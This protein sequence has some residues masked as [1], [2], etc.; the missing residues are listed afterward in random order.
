MGIYDRIVRRLATISK[1]SD[2]RCQHACAMVNYRSGE[3]VAEGVNYH[4]HK[5]QTKPWIRTKRKAT[6]HAEEVVWIKF[7]KSRKSDL[8]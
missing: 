1:Q 7:L 8:D 6:M 3:I 5:K 2:V 4:F